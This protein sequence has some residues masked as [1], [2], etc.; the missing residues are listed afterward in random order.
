VEA[1]VGPIKYVAAL[2]YG[3]QTDATMLEKAVRWMIILIVAVFD[4][5]AI[6]MLL[7]ATESMKWER[8]RRA[9]QPREETRDGTDDDNDTGASAGVD[10]PDDRSMVDE[11]PIVE[12]VPIPDE[13]EIKD[14]KPVDSP[15]DQL[16]EVS[17]VAV[18]DEEES[19]DETDEEKRARRAWKEANPEDT[20]HRQKMLLEQGKIDRLPWQESLRPQADEGSHVNVDFGTTF[21]SNPA[22]GDT[23]IRVDYLPSKLYKWNGTKWIEVDKDN[24][25]SFT[26][27]ENYIDHLIAKIS[28]GEYDPELLNDNER[29]QIEQRLRNDNRPGGI[30]V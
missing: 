5:L 20:I 21:P 15:Q 30:N 22:K 8:Q 4:P 3:D 19:S 13:T 17:P 7:A 26:Y 24:T 12:V 28:S 9:Q 14:P 10:R 11:Q 25:D 2:I 6:M 16:T 27:N 29:E 1:E 23:Y 18:D